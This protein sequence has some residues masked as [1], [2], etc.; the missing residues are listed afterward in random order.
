MATRLITMEGR[1]KKKNF[2][3]LHRQLVPAFKRF[4]KMVMFTTISRV[5]CVLI[6]KL[7][8]ICSTP[9]V[10]HAENGQSVGN[11]SRFSRTQRTAV[12][13]VSCILSLSDI[14]WSIFPVL[15]QHFFNL[16]HILYLFIS[17]QYG[18]K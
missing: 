18:T 1:G 12:S 2:R 4:H 3:G 13:I 5:K 11:Y 16:H 9:S 15:F 10:V 14:S 8:L 7:I 6:T 17:V